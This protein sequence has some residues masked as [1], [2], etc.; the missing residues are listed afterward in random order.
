MMPNNDGEDFDELTVESPDEITDPDE[1]P[2][3]EDEDD[4][5]E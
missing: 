3:N 2:S 4:S 5:E 1:G